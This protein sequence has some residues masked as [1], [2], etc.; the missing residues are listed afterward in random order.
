[1]SQVLTSAYS[2][3]MPVRSKII[4]KSNDGADT[5]FTHDGFAPN[6]STINVIYSDCERASGETGSFNIIVED[7]DNIIN[8]DHLQNTKVY[9]LLGK[10]QAGLKY[11]FVGKGRIFNVRRPRSFYQEYLI[12]GPS[13][14]T[15]AAELMLLWRKSTDK[16]NN[17]D[18]NIG[19][20]VIDSMTDSKPRPLNREAFDDITG[21]NIGYDDEE[22][23]GGISPLL[24]AINLPVVNEVF[25]SYWDWLDR[26]AALTGAP[27]DLDFNETTGDE[28]LTM[29]Y[30][31]D[32]HSGVTIKS[33]DL[34]SAIDRADKTA[35]IYDEFN[36]ENNSTSDVGV[37]T[38]LYTTT[39]IDKKS[40]SASNHNHGSANLVSKAIAQQIIIENDQ[41]RITSI[42]L[43]LSKVGDPES[44]KDRVNGDIVLDFGDNTP[45]GTVLATFQIPLSDI[46]TEA[47]TIFVD[48]IDIKV[49]FLQGNNKIWIR[50]FQRSGLDGDPNTD[51]TNT[52]KWH[53]SGVFGIAQPTFSAISSNNA[54]DYKLKDTMTWSTAALGPTYAYDVFS[55]IRRLQA[56]TNASAA[57]KLDI[58]ETFYD[59]SHL[60]D[61][62]S[63]NTQLA[64]ALARRSKSRQTIPVR[65]TVPNNFLYKPYQLV[66]FN[67]GLSNQFETRQVA[68]ARYVQSSQPGENPIGAMWAD[69]TLQGEINPLIGSCSC[70]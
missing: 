42:G 48:D 58:I 53:H 44:P 46:K 68:R 6:P 13:T 24:N 28:V 39:I 52:V 63:V 43:I 62:R 14:K 49:R 64:L 29:A 41:R 2:Y 67:D 19:Q 7:S 3:L 40:V 16:T 56:R 31:Q 8:K 66:D 11:W 59:T 69:I 47:T 57:K 60:S 36:M 21:W 45:R 1:M 15:R 61:F 54:G 26:N 18:Y 37:A 65:V 50:L 10:E 33:G 38:R 55:N 27:W 51:S 9:I 32:R 35:Y 5:Y 20:L 25:T 23:Q 4:F 17:P 30:P 34:K 22:D 70:E 12:S